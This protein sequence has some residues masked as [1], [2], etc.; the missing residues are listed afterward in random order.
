[1]SMMMCMCVRVCD[2]FR[3]M[4]H[5]ETWSTFA[6]SDL[7]CTKTFGYCAAIY[8]RM[9]ITRVSKG[10]PTRLALHESWHWLHEL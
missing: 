7:Q 4:T 9:I 10:N 8:V 6:W 3:F 5:F 2:L 1:M